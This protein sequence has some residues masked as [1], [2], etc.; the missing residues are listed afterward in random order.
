M[1]GWRL[2]NIKPTLITIKVREAG[3]LTAEWEPSVIKRPLNRTW[4]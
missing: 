2:A 1:S 3:T 4:A